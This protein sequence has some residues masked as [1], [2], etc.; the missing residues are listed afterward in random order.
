MRVWVVFLVVVL[1]FA[2]SPAA[3]ANVVGNVRGIV[4][5]P[6]HR[7][8]PG[9]E[10]RLNA[11]NSSWSQSTRTND[12][13]EFT[14]P[15]VPVGEYSVTISASQ[16]QTAIQNVSVMVNSSPIL[17]FV[18]AI[19]AVSETATVTAETETTATETA[20]PTTLVNRSEIQLTPGADQANSLGMIT[21]YVPGS[22]MTHDMLHIRGGHQVSWLIDGVPIPNLNI[23]VN[24]GPQIDPKDV[25]FVDVQRGSYD[26]EYGDRTYGIFDVVPK[27]GFDMNNEGQ[28]VTSFG[29]HY[30][31]DDQLSFGGHS[32]TLAY[33]AS[34]DG[35]RS[36]LGLETPI[37]Q[38]YHD[39]DNGVGVFGSVIYNAGPQDQFRIVGSLRRDFYQIP[40]D[41][42]PS[43]YENQELGPPGT[44]DL[45][46]NEVE[47][48]GYGLFSWIH[49]FNANTVLTVSPFY[50]Y[51]S[52]GYHSLN[53]DVPLATTA[54]FSSNYGGGQATLNFHLPRN[55]TQVG[56]YAFTADQNENFNLIFN[57]GSGNPPIPDVK[58]VP[59]SDIAAFISDKFTV[60]SWL[61]LIGGIRATHFSGGVA[62]NTAY[63]RIGGT[64]RIPRV[65]WVFRA[66]WGKFYQPPP[67]VT[68]SGPLLG[69]LSQQT[70]MGNPTSF[71]PL[72]G[73]RDEEHQFGVT[74]PIRGWALDIDSFETRGVNFL[75]HNNIGESN[76]FI[77]VTFSESRI[78]GTEV[79]VRSPRVW[80]IADMHLAYS[81]QM[82]QAQGTQTGGLILGSPVA[83]PG[84]GPLDHDQRNTLNVGFNSDLPWQSYAAL[85]V[86][87]GSGF[88][89]GDFGNAGT[90]YENDAY[91]PGHTTVDLSL[92]KKFGESYSLSVTA[93]N[94]NDSHLLIDNSLTFGGFHYNNPREVYVQFRYRFHY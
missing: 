64:L 89:N 51:N 86:Y 43:D 44:A 2:C 87:Y 94:I 61:T 20:T 81:N 19:A 69:Y 85:N 68:I 55:D 31:T 14:F 29:N 52:A 39:A 21:D 72:D 16:F 42:N 56:I 71:E 3:L 77:P 1:S 30:Q 32:D 11:A 22:Y 9:A 75:D 53:N 33:Y 88:T 45:R 74:I 60:N 46:D 10:V 73:E 54:I 6:Q 12:D 4:H 92:G 25:D 84:W 90:P 62:E 49:T 28:L 57:D 38:V 78:R 13:G 67:L 58:S 50:H 70:S 63:P 5:D 15:A 66:F 65:N 59:G 79:T 35:N 8:I 26:A 91:L 80:K 82:A 83:P 93:L 41:P 27:N 23:A 24:L 47:A 48:D 40:Y 37:S 7:P 18:L 76:I 34:L 17:H 36:N